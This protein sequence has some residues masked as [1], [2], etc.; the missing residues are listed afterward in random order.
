MSLLSRKRNFNWL[1]DLITGDEKWVLYINTTRRRQWI[2]P[3]DTSIPTPKPEKHQEKVMLSVW[4]GVRGIAHWELLPTNST[5]TSEVYCAQLERLKAK[6]EADHP[7]RGKVYFLHDNARPHVAKSTRQKLMTF[8][9]D[10]LPLPA[11]STD[12]A[13]SDY[14]LFLALSNKLRD[15]H[16]DEPSNIESYLEDFFRSQPQEFYREGIRSLAKR[17]QMVVDNDGAYIID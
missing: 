12:L 17:W 13:P 2:R 10:I 4:W 9:W 8:G 5:V 1:D 11:Y 14:H 3:G 6:L 15:M 16:F 7:R